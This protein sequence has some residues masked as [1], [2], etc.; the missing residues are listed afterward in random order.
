IDTLLMEIERAKKT[1]DARVVEVK[2]AHNTARKDVARM[3]EEQ[4]TEAQRVRWEIE[5]RGRAELTSA[6]N[7]A[8][9]L[10]RLAESYRDNRAVLQ[11]ELA[12]RRLDVGA[13]LAEQR[14]EEHTSE[15]QSREN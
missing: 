5:A 1:R 14:S 10:R 13:K 8:K 9:A 11:Y 12:R 7:E 2:A 4:E 15:L 3:L 6:E